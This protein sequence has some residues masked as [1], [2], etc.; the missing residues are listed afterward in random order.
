MDKY[1]NFG[2]FYIELY[3]SQIYTYL[4]LASVGKEQDFARTGQQQGISGVKCQQSG[5]ESDLED[6]HPK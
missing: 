4:K 3:L 2:N 6:L 1:R 5:L